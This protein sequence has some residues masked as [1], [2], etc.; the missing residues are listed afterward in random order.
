MMTNPTKAEI[1]LLS[2]DV[3]TTGRIAAAGAKLGLACSFVT[4]NDQVSENCVLLF[5]DVKATGPWEHAV[6]DARNRAT[7]VI[8]FAQH[9][10]TEGIQRAR[11]AGCHRVIAKSK[12]AAD[13]GMILREVAE[14]RG[15]MP[16]STSWA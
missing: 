12:L 16:S 2:D 6:Q 1:A 5:V 10:D 14:T 15:V 11:E 13:V 8:A 3:F 9:T 4:A 7:T